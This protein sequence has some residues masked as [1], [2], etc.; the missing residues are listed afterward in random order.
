VDGF[1]KIVG[2]VLRRARR[3]RGLTL[4]DVDRESRGGFKPSTIAGYERGERMITIE[5]FR[6][7]A[8]IYR[9]PADRLLADVLDELVPERRHAIEIDLNSLPLLAERERRLVAEFVHGV[10]ARRGAFL[11]DV[12]RLRS[13]DVAALALASHLTPRSLLSRLRP[14]LR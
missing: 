6:A 4:H 7:L 14:A 10:R 3:R 1:S 9:I 12:V 13:D 2:Q 8:D 5:R 11:A